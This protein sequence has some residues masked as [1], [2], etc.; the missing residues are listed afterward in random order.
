MKKNKLALDENIVK[1]I[2]PGTNPDVA[3]GEDGYVI[4]DFQALY[5]KKLAIFVP[6][7]IER[8]H[9]SDV[10]PKSFEA[11]FKDL[12]SEIA[13]LSRL[14]EANLEWCLKGRGIEFIAG[15]VL[16]RQDNNYTVFRFD[17]LVDTC[18]KT[19]L[20][21]RTE[22]K[23][24]TVNDEMAVLNTDPYFEDKATSIDGREYL[25]WI[26]PIGQLFFNTNS[27][28]ATILSMAESLN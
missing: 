4:Y 2:F 3:L 19:E 11:Y 23:N 27:L 21:C 17:E 9:Y 15:R 20:L 5:P 14:L 7:E 24:I 18:C 16:K 8:S 6:I 12:D 10:F 26:M 13:R 1:Y 22:T 28:I 25:Y